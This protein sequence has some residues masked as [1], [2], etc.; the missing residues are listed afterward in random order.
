MHIEIGPVTAAGTTLYIATHGKGFFKSADSGATWIKINNGIDPVLHYYDE[1]KGITNWDNVP[2]NVGSNFFGR[3]IRWF[4]DGTPDGVLYGMIAR[5]GAEF[6]GEASGQL[7]R[8]NDGG[9]NW[10]KCAMP[11]FPGAPNAANYVAD[12]DFDPRNPDTIYAAC[13]QSSNGAPAYLMC[14]PGQE[15]PN[16]GGV[17][18]SHDAG[19]SWSLVWGPDRHVYGI[20][21]DPYNPNNV[22]AVTFEGEMMVM[23]YG[24]LGAELSSGAGAGYDV[25]KWVIHRENGLQFRQS[26]SPFIDVN[27]PDFVFVSSFGGNI[28]RGPSH[29]APKLKEIT[30]GG[31]AIADFDANV[32]EYVIDL[33]DGSAGDGSDDA[34]NV[35]DG[36]DI[37]DVVD[38]GAAGVYDTAIIS[39]VG[40]HGL[41]PGENIITITVANEIETLETVYTII[42]IVPDDIVEPVLVN[43]APSA[44]VTKLTGNQNDLTITVKET[45]SDASVVIITKTI[46][47]NNNAAATYEVGD[48]KVYVDTK[49]NDQ[50]RDCKIVG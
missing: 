20:Q 33:S 9:A 30:F 35:G 34:G 40:E 19:A 21:V 45:Y 23:Q 49:G 36:I 37:A 25:G 8:S 22:F 39:G 42:V 12:L 24:G 15:R 13:W 11:Q 38:I 27:H 48:Y 10:V 7:Y 29:V 47:I 17:Y 26:C 14:D 31:E 18:I 28:W 5:S 16:S 2:A 44:F 43:T 50:I 32:F 41:T 46:K 3:K 4:D 1:I 6:T